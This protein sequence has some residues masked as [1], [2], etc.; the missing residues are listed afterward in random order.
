MLLVDQLAVAASVAGIA[1]ADLGLV[2]AAVALHPYI[3][4]TEELVFGTVAVVPEESVDLPAMVP[5]EVLSS[6]SAA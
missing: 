3:A 1:S 4:G 2:S 5:A 6:K